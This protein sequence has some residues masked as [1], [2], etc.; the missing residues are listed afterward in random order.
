M[1]RHHKQGN[2]YKRKHV[3]GD[4]SIVSSREVGYGGRHDK[5]GAGE[6]AESYILSSRRQAGT[7]QDTGPGMGF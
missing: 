2:F 3:I 5:H 6:I 4:L 7:E 1:K